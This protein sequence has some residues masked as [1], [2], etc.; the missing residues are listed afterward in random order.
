MK[1]F[2]GENYYQILN[3]PES[4]GAKEIRRAYLNT[5]EI[6]QE[7]SIAT[8]SLFSSEEREI[9][10]QVIQKAFDTLIDE[11]K[12]TAYNRMLVETGQVDSAFLFRMPTEKPAEDSN[13]QS[14]SKEKSLDQWVRKRSETS[15]IKTLIEQIMSE[16]LV[17]GQD[18]KR[19]R[20]AFGIEIH[21]IYTITRISSSILK[22]IEADRYN[23][24]PAEIFLKQFL[25]TYSEILQIDPQ[26][27]ISGYFRLMGRDHPTAG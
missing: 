19:L 27:V 16:E 4:A 5:L 25:K 12:R 23:D 22:L 6:Y 17:S 14:I 26:H 3:V 8:Y 7:D 11:N 20:E 1:T 15:E 10:L 2:E 18:L 9:L 21:E 24:L 13:I